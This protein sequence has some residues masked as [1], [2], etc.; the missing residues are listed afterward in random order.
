MISK[1]LFPKA[2][3]LSADAAAKL[4]SGDKLAAFILKRKYGLA[5]GAGSTVNQVLEA[6][7]CKQLGFSD[8]TT[9]EGLLRVIL[10]RLCGSERLPKRSLVKQ[11]CCSRPATDRPPVPTQARGKIVQQEHD[12]GWRRHAA[13]ARIA[14]PRAV[15]PG[16]L[17]CDPPSAGGHESTPRS[18]PRQQGSMLAAVR[19]ESQQEPN[20]RDSF[21]ARVQAAIGRGEFAGPPTSEPHADTR[22]GN[23]PADGGRFWKR[24][25]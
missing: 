14:T 5:A 3:G 22:S 10:S 1:Y 23:G 13:I 17:C 15:R 2:A 18:V 4:D 11:L 24:R 16:R 19:R 6:V 25:G 9:L 7:A 12:V 8:E 20:P 21:P